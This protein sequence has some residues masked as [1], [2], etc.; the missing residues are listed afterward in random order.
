M[1]SHIIPVE[2]LYLRRTAPLYPRKHWSN[3]PSTS[4]ISC[5]RRHDG[6]LDST[7]RLVF[8]DIGKKNENAIQG[9]QKSNTIKIRATV[10]LED[11]GF[12]EKN[13]RLL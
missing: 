8:V 1:V 9:I 12:G 6:G 4:G 10:D 13:Y 3:H 2:S 7:F 11:A 5:T